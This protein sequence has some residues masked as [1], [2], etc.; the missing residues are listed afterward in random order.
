LVVELLLAGTGSVV[1]DA[2]VTVFE[3]WAGRGAVEDDDGKGV[4]LAQRGGG[5]VKVTVP[6]PPTAGGWCSIG[7]RRGG[8]NVGPRE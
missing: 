8:T 5:L 2:T 1:S 3:R 7:R 6:V 4:L